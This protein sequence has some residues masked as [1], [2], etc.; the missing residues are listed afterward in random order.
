MSLKEFV[1]NSGLENLKKE[2]GKLRALAAFGETVRKEREQEVARMGVALELGMTRNELEDM[3]LQLEDDT[4]EK[5]WK[6]LDGK[7]RKL[8]GGGPQLTAEAG[9]QEEKD[10]YLI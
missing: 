1:E 6:G 8:H 10:A 4:L 2:L 5:L 7:M 9:K 3:A